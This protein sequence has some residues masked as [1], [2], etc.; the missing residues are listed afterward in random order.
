MKYYFARKRD[1]QNATRKPMFATTKEEAIAEFSED[2][3]KDIACGNDYFLYQ[4]EEDYLNDFPDK[5]YMGEGYYISPDAVTFG[6]EDYY[7]YNARFETYRED[8]FSYY[9][10]EEDD[11][12]ETPTT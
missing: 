1:G 10:Q 2:I 5:K 7:P 6:R 9:I 12:A 3:L 8:V 4:S 11:T